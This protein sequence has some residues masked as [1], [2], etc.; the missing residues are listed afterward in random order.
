MRK[1][2]HDLTVALYKSFGFKRIEGLANSYNLKAL[3][4]LAKDIPEL[5]AMVQQ[6]K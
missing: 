6:K 5:Q 4:V 2:A 3:E 1:L